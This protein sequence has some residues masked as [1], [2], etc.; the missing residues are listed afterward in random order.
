MRVVGEWFEVISAKGAQCESLA[1]QPSCSAGD[2]A[3]GQRPRVT[4]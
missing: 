4:H 3:L 1:P 2:P